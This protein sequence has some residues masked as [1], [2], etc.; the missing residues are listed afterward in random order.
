MFGFFFTKEKK[1]TTFDQVTQCNI[2]QFNQFF[3]TM[4]DHGIYLAPSAYEA[5]FVSAAHTIDDINVTLDKA[6]TAFAAL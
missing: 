5:G 3:N 2:E 6:E 1:V 4:L